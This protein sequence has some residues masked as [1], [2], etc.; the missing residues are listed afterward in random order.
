MTGDNQ[1]KARGIAL[2]ALMIM[3]VFVAGIGFT[4]AVA[5][6]GHITADRSI[7]SV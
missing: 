1:T 5:A 3:S 4:G 6:D 2:A 7:D